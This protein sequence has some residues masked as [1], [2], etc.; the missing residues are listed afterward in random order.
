[1]AAQG[2][3]T[4]GVLDVGQTLLSAAIPAGRNACPTLYK[5]YPAMGRFKM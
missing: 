2:F 4:R 5:F 1:M 3:V